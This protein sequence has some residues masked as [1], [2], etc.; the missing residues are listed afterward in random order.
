[1][2]AG[3]ANSPYAVFGICCPQ[4]KKKRNDTDKNGEAH[5]RLLSIQKC[6]E[7]FLVL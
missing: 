3:V 4:A 6:F 1:M 5:E 2:I 7:Q